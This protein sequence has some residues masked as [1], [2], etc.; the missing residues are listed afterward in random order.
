M[1]NKRMIP[2]PSEAGRLDVHARTML[3]A[4]DI[5]GG[6]GPLADFLRVPRHE[7]LT[8]MTGAE[9]PPEINFLAAGDI[10]LGDHQLLRKAF[11]PEVGSKALLR[12]DPPKP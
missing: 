10:L 12:N 5:L 9:R 3:A 1:H 7:L 2:V 6:I 11:H 8:W 4:A